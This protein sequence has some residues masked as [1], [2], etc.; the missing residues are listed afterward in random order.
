M[1]LGVRMRNNKEIE[2]SVCL[3][4]LEEVKNCSIF[5]ICFHNGEFVLWNKS[6]S[7]DPLFLTKEEVRCLGRQLI[8]WANSYE[9]K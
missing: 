2:H 4:V 1:V 3:N 6:C 8:D 9:Q 7:D 5:E